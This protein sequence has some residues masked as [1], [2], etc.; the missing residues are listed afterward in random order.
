MAVAEILI[1][2]IKNEYVHC[3]LHLGNVLVEQY[4]ISE[5]DTDDYIPK[6]KLIDFGNILNLTSID[7]V[8][9]EF[10]STLF[11]ADADVDYAEISNLD[12]TDL[13]YEDFKNLSKII[14][15]IARIDYAKNYTTYG[16]K[17]DN[18]QM[19]EILKSLYGED[20]AREF[21]SNPA[22]VISGIT[23]EY[24]EYIRQYYTILISVPMGARNNLS[25]LAI[26]TMVTYKKIFS[27]TVAD[28]IHL[29]RDREKI[30][31]YNNPA[32]E[33]SRSASESAPSLKRQRV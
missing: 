30:E 25:K 17:I 33:T 5:V 11:G 28:D 20:N 8:I 31:N 27:I 10:Y 15:F 7:L 26:E 6:V 19:M 12:I 3:D 23:E 1:L 22:F 16:E 14:R 32:P 18:P 13:W 24:Y 4:N 9:K 2:F 21:Y 29:H